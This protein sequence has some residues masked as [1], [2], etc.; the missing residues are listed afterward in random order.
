M[1]HLRH[2][3]SFFLI[4]QAL[5]VNGQR[6]TGVVTDAETG[7]SIPMVSVVYKGH[8]VAVISSVNGQYSI[9]RQ[10]NQRGR[11]W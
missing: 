10:L 5:V 9:A 7:D 4:L 11:F 3:L 2:I 6:I 1:S 8:N